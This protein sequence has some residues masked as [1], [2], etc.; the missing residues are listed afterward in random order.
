MLEVQAR[1]RSADAEA[2]GLSMAAAVDRDNTWAALVF[3]KRQAC[4]F[5]LNELVHRLPMFAQHFSTGAHMLAWTR[6]L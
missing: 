3:C 5:A 2:A 6:G 1:R 4:A